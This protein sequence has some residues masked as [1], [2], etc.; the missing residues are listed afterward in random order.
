MAKR[1]VKK[2]HLSICHM[3]AGEL[4]GLDALQGG[5]SLDPKTGLR[6]Y[7]MLGPIIE[8]QDV[9]DV[10]KHVA[11]E[12]FFKGEISSKL[13]VV[14]KEA[15][16]ATLPFAP[17]PVEHNKKI[18]KLSKGTPPDLHAALLPD[19]LI[20]FLLSLA[21]PSEIKK[22][23]K[24]GLLEFGWFNEIVKI[25]GTILGGVGGFLTGGPAGAALGAGLG[26]VA[27]RGVTS[28]FEKPFMDYAIG[29]LKNAALGYAAP[30]ALGS[31]GLM[32]AGAPGIGAL[33]GLS[34]VAAGSTMTGGAG[35]G[36][37][38][39]AAATASAAGA[40]AAP[41]AVGPTFT[42]TFLKYAPLGVL[43]LSMLGQKKH[44]H[45]QLNMHK[46][47]EHNI[48]A[49][50]EKLGYN[51]K[52]EQLTPRTLKKNPDFKVDPK[53]GAV[54]GPMYIDSGMKYKKGGL[55]QSYNKGTLVKGKGTG[56]SDEIKTSVPN[57]SYIIDAS[58]TSDLGDGSSEAGGKVLKA[59]ENHIKAK[60]GRARPIVE[61]H[62]KKQNKGVPVWLSNDE[63]MF[64]PTTVT[65]LGH[66]SNAQGAKV[67]KK[68]VHNLRVHKNSNGTGLPPKAK[69]P[70][71][72]IRKDHHV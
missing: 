25:G 10:F 23:K 1:N 42:G 39:N 54:N 57:G 61:K 30:Y 36:M 50:R 41:A 62:I 37:G 19:N 66:G 28:N 34:P 16:K 32:G 59:F 67:L 63:Y 52:W 43:G 18:K 55:V 22:S 68:M 7:S 13:R 12:L 46:E 44:H 17:A 60:F 53:T 71:D 38:G 20:L 3:T 21:P 2:P 58:S 72:Y 11:Q 48:E 45:H 49:E 4:E 15:K 47:H 27:S 31:M 6:E 24:D 65:L 35:V 33:M 64:D 5:P 26:N 70:L 40:S 8:R 69:N 29:G 14:Y 9:Q 56:Q 51:R